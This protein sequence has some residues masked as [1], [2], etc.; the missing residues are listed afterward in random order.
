LAI[1][2]AQPDILHVMMPHS[3]L[4]SQK[5]INLAS[6]VPT[7]GTF[8]IYPANYVAIIGSRLLRLMYLRG[9]RRIDA[10]VS[11]STAARTFARRNFHI[12]S[13]VIPNMVDISKFVN[14]KAKRNPSQIVFIGRLVKRKGC[15]Q[16]IRAFAQVH[17]EIPGSKLII[18][19]DGPERA[20]LQRLVKRLGLSPDV[21]FKGYV[22]EE[23]KAD[24]LASSAVACFPSLYGESFGIVL[25]EAM[26][27]GSGVVLA[28]NN[29]GYR[30]VMG[31][32]GSAMFDP[33]KPSELS[34]KIIHFMNDKTA[35]AEVHKRQSSLV[36]KF[37]VA[38]VGSQIER[39]YERAIANHS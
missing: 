9:L 29:P 16:L 21:E 38:E 6:D 24:L 36:K 23:K 31:S 10:I 7:V 1:N 13:S 39:L 12:N 11:V 3:P 33:T 8:H 14:T 26:A 34:S 25:I 2:E 37:D 17:K 30:S 20:S 28:G 35:A 32:I 18:G 22:K 27:A 5:V 19:G 4:M 15:A